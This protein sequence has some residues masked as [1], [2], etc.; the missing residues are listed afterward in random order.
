MRRIGQLRGLIGRLLGLLLKTGLPLMKNVLK[1]LAK[2]SL[3]PLWLTAATSA[4]NSAIQK[5]NFGLR[6]TILIIS[7]KEMTE[8][9]KINQYF[10]ESG[11]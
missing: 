5:K 9:I 6:M 2:S 11:L 10:E 3:I 8:I 4:T 7:N 1:T